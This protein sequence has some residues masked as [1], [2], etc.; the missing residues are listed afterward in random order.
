MSA[1]S[2]ILRTKGKSVVLRVQERLRLRVL[3]LFLVYA[4]DWLS[5]TKYHCTIFTECLHQ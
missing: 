2:I 4:E 5:I 3:N 1:E